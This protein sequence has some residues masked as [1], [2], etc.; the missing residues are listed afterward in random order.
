MIA[1][2]RNSRLTKLKDY[3]DKKLNFLKMCI[4]LDKK[5]V[6]WV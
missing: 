4:L 1:A 2:F 5:G 6:L 3:I